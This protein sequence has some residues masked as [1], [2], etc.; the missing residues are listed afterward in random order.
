MKKYKKEPIGYHFGK[1]DIDRCGLFSDPGYLIGDKYIHTSSS[2]TRT[3][4]R[5]KQFSLGIPT[6]KSNGLFDPE[7]KSIYVGDKY[8]EPWKRELTVAEISGKRWMAP[9][10]AKKHATPGDTFGTFTAHVEAFSPLIKSSKPKIKEPRN[11]FVY[12]PKKGGPGYADITIS[13]FPTYE[14]SKK[15][16]ERDVSKVSKPK[17]MVLTF[18]PKPYF[19]TGNPFDGV[20]ATKRRKTQKQKPEK[21]FF[22]PSFPKKPGNNH[23]GC[24]TKFPEWEPVKY[25]EDKTDSQQENKKKFLPWGSEKSLYFV[26]VMSNK[27]KS[28]CN[29]KTCR[30]IKPI[31]YP[32][33]NE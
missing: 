26:S 29:S 16:K 2:C 13:K 28:A 9:P 19:E 8:I 14:T 5:G 30:S 20:T 32:Q 4:C 1:R 10:S 6:V 27:L 25:K 12:P 3:V 18:H 15:R 23:A 11:F 24:F 33:Y 31:T 21:I 17:T 7:Y 22:P